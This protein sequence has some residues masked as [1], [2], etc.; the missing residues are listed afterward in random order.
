MP[1]CWQNHASGMTAGAFYRSG[2]FQFRV[3][4]LAAQISLAGPTG[5]R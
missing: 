1:R 4:D 3:S 5:G 2:D